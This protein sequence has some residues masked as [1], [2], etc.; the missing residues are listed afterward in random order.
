[1]GGVWYKAGSNWNQSRCYKSSTMSDENVGAAEGEIGV[2][3][4]NSSFI[5]CAHSSMYRYCK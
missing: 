5:L 3:H 4:L 2:F 1:M